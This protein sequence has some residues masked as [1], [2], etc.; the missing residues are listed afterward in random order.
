MIHYCLWCKKRV[1]MPFVDKH[2]VFCSGKCLANYL[3][4]YPPQKVGRGFPLPPHFNFRSK[5]ELNFAKKF[6][7]AYKL[8]WKYEP[9]AFRL[10]NLKWYIPDFEVNGHFIEI[11]GI[12]EA[13]ARKKAK[14]FRKEYGNL[15][16]L[17]KL[18]L[19]KV[20]VL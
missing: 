14:M 13:G 19:K 4:S 9:Y 17:D 11:K 6:C 8:K 10:S 16:I 20:G 7:E 15:L 5:W 2:S 3:I 12:W 1:I 18:I